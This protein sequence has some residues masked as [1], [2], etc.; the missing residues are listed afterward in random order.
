M[1]EYEI[2]KSLVQKLSIFED[3][4]N[5]HHKAIL[6]DEP[7]LASPN[8]TSPS[9]TCSSPTIPGATY[10]LDNQTRRRGR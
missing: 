4:V 5:C 9:I 6:P 1:V 3:S 7:K 8:S 2:T 10:L